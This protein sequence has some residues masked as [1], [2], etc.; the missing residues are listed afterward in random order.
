[1]NEKCCTNGCKNEI[2]FIESTFRMEHCDECEKLLM[3]A[4]LKK[5]RYFFMQR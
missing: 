1:M 2:G 3:S 5:D 4:N